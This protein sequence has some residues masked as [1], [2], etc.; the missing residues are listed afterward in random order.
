[1]MDEF[2]FEVKY[3]YIVVYVTTILA[4][5]TVEIHID[6]NDY[7]EETCWNKT[8]MEEELSCM[9][10]EVERE[11]GNRKFKLGKQL[12]SKWVGN[13]SMFEEYKLVK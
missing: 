8:R 1:M 12:Q 13:E 11:I 4:S 2:E 6:F 9:W 7:A 3:G 5:Q 10:M